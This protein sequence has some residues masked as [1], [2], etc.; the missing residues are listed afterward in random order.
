[1]TDFD[2]E[3][4]IPVHNPTASRFELD[5]GDGQLGVVEYDLRDTTLTIHHTGV[6]TAFEGRGIAG[7]MTKATLAWAR[8]QGY[9]II[10]ICSYTRA[11]MLRH[12]D[13]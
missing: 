13:E 8:A 3:A 5:L 12:P 1:M 9:K 10:P 4:L 7:I 6:P 11:Y 2:T